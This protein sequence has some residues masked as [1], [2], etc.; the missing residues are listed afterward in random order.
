VLLR[1]VADRLGVPLFTWTRSQGLSRADLGDM[2]YESP[3]A[4]KAVQHVIASRQDAVY[5][6]RSFAHTLTGNDLL[7]SL[8][9]DA[10]PRA[11]WSNSGAPSCSPGKA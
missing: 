5:H 3:D 10:T 7:T 9:R 1:H 4:T 2:I 6:F 8:V 11:A